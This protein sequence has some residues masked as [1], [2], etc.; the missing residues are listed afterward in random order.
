MWKTLLQA[1]IIITLANHILFVPNTRWF[2]ET[3]AYIRQLIKYL[4]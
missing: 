1:I 4:Y 2:M 3:I